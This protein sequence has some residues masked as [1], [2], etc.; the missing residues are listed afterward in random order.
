M[1]EIITNPDERLISE[2][3][4]LY[5]SV[6]PERKTS[7]ARFRRRLMLDSGASLPIERAEG[8]LVGFAVCYR[9]GLLMLAVEQSFRGR[10]I[11]SALLREC[12]ALA[13]PFGQLRLGYAASGSYLFCGA[14]VEA[15][16][17]FDHRGYSNDWTAC[18]CLLA[19]EDFTPSE[20]ECD[21]SV[22]IGTRTDGERDEAFALANRVSHWGDFWAKTDELIVARSD[23][24]LV[25]G[26]MLEDGCLF[27]G[28]IERSCTLGC[29]GVDADYRR[30]GIAASLCH[31]LANRA[32]SRGYRNIFIGYTHI[33]D[34]YSRLGAK[35]FA[36]Y[37][38]GVKKL[39]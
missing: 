7:L 33:S 16:G 5:N 6:F 8:R 17:F 38:F 1:P 28:S 39:S 24:R 34:W 11:G 18:D 12:E 25:G 19:V 14:P 35:I 27:E 23:G 32:K 29:L 22:S 3:L 21:A 13:S 26:V 10:G 4:G 15:N 9:D 36:S 2:A 31:E 30:R 37:R 20:Q